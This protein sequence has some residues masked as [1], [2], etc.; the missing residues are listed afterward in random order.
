MLERGAELFPELTERMRERNAE[1]PYRR[2]FTYALERVRAARRDRPGAYAGPEELLD[3]LRAAAHALSQGPG[4]AAA[5]GDLH[6]VIRQVEVFGFHFARLDVR[7]NAK[8]HRGRAGRDPR[9]S[10]RSA[11]ATRSCPPGERCEVL[12]RA[13]ADHR[14]LIPQDVSGFS[15]S[16]Q[17]CVQTFRSLHEALTGRH[18]DTDRGVRGLAHR[19]PAGPAGGAA[20]DEGVAPVARRRPRRDAADRPAV[21]VRRHARGRARHAG[22]P[23]G[24]ARLPRRAGGDG[25]PP[26]GHGRLLGLEQGRGLRGLGLG[27]LPRPAGHRRGARAPRRVVG[28][29][30]RPRRCGRPRRRAHQHRHPGAARG[31][32]RRPAEGHRAG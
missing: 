13:I 19:G 5:A 15:D 17:E 11:R 31:H 28:V 10:S 7:E 3:D 8:V 12:C 22:R 18:R 24:A 20:A 2:A 21:R 6:D 14:P 26:G 9:A 27:H 29:L 1:E 25:R 23:D 30:P 4:G 32:G 16:T